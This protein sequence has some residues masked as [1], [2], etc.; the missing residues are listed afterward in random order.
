[1][2]MT[3]RHRWAINAAPIRNE[4]HFYDWLVPSFTNGF[5]GI[6]W[7]LQRIVWGYGYKP[8]RLLFV[9]L[10][11]IFFFASIFILLGCFKAYNPLRQILYSILLSTQS[12]FSMSYG[13]TNP[14]NKY[15]EALGTLEA[16]IGTILV[17][18][19]LVAL[20]VKYM[21]RS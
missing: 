20:T 9:I 12:F 14:T 3:C 18:F 16:L 6:W 19:F 10:F 1:M 8:F 4:S 7:Y 5:K 13:L 11:I 2:A 17:S 15:F 21:R